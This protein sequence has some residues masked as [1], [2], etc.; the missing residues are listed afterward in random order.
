MLPVSILTLASNVLLADA[1]LSLLGV[2]QEISSWF[3]GLWIFYSLPLIFVGSGVASAKIHD[4]ILKR[5]FGISLP[6]NDQYRFK[7]FRFE[8]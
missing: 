3:V 5:I 2:A 8:R 6:E 1:L 4:L 7:L